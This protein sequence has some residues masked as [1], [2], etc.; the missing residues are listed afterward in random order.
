MSVKT[1]KLNMPE[2]DKPE[3]YTDGSQIMKSRTDAFV[4]FK[5]EIIDWL[6]DQKK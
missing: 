5:E 6:K 2:W 1:F 4:E 3:I